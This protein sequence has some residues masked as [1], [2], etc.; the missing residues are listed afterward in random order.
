VAVFDS[1]GDTLYSGSKSGLL[2]SP[3]G[4]IEGDYSH[5]KFGSRVNS[6]G[7]INGDG[8]PDVLLIGP[9]GVAITSSNT[10]RIGRA[11]V[12][13]GS[14]K[15]LPFYHKLSLE[16]PF[17]LAAEEKLNRYRQSFGSAFYWAPLTDP[18]HDN[19]DSVVAF[20]GDYATGFFSEV[21]LRCHLDLPEILPATQVSAAWRHNLFAAIKEALNNIARHAHAKTVTLKVVVVDEETVAVEI[22]D[23]GCGLQSSP[24]HITMVP[25]NPAADA[26][27]HSKGN[28]NGL[29]NIAARLSALRGK[30]VISSSPKWGTCI[31]LEV[32]VKS[33]A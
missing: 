24:I 8:Y 19:L 4:I 7:D 21:G 23:D 15:G 25:S 26:L 28:G 11:M 27:L 14:P 29:A 6:A 12:C 18:R 20:I 2:R 10:V 9:A 32:P 22:E 31:Q 16:K 13:Y 1:I 17:F 5:D 33:E 30:A 3:S